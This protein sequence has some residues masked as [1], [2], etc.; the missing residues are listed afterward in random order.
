MKEGDIKKVIHE[1]GNARWNRD[2]EERVL[3]LYIGI[4][5]KSYKR[6]YI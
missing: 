2:M 1:Y 3:S 6:S 5:R 4:V